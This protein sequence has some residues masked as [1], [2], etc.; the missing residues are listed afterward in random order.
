MDTLFRQHLSEKDKFGLAPYAEGCALFSALVSL[1][2]C[3]LLGFRGAQGG[4]SVFSV[5]SLSSAGGAFAKCAALMAMLA[6]RAHDWGLS[7]AWALLAEVP[8]ANIL[9]IVAAL[10]VPGRPGGRAWPSWDEA[11]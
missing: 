7:G 5:F 10:T 9:L 1:V 6:R 11:D 8:V 3:F 2:F 4:V